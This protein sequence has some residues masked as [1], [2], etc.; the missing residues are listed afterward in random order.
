M[1]RISAFILAILFLFS[2]SGLSLDISRC[3]SDFTGISLGYNIHEHNEAPGCCECLEEQDASPCCEDIILQT[4]INTVPASVMV[5]QLELKK[6]FKSPIEYAA[7]VT[8][9]NN[10]L[11]HVNDYPKS[12]PD[13]PRQIPIL[14]QKRVLII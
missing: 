2:G 13:L 4:Q 6:E 1:N 10:F 11:N 9:F 8:D 7:Q 14:I 12:T 5:H 3:C